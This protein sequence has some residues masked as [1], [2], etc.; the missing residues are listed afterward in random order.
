MPIDYAKHPYT[1]PAE[2]IRALNAAPPEQRI[3]DSLRKYETAARG[4]SS[5]CDNDWA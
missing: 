4:T 5:V 3:F 2:R 1:A